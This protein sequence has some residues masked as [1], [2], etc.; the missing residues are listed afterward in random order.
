MNLLNSFDFESFD[1][2]K[3]CLLGNITKSPFTKSSERASDLLD[4]FILMFMV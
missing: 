1:I 2:C 3:S 4:Y